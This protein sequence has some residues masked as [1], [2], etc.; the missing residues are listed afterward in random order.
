MR[1]LVRRKKLRNLRTS[2]NTNVIYRGIY[3]KFGYITKAEVNGM[4]VWNR[5]G[6]LVILDF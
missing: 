5:M 3:L 2:L 4:K 6:E 1:N